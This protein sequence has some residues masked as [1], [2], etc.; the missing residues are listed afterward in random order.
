M[1]F[2]HFGMLNWFSTPAE[3]RILIIAFYSSLFWFLSSLCHSSSPNTFIPS[4]VSQDGCQSALPG[5]SSLLLLSSSILFMR[6]ERLL[7]KSVL[8]SI[9]YGTYSPSW[10]WINSSH[11]SATGYLHENQ[12]EICS[13]TA[14][15]TGSQCMNTVSFCLI[16]LFINSWHA[17]DHL[18]LP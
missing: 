18:L 13:S 2:S 6:V 3:F 16:I 1:V 11:V 14:Y 10:V 9:R 15:E 12:R 17:H 8:V 5:H 4:P 7:P